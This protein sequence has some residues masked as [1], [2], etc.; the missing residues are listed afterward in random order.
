M[1][2]TRRPGQKPLPDEKAKAQETFL[3]VF[4]QTAIVGMAARKA[5]IARSTVYSWLD[6]DPDFKAAFELA[7]KDANDRLREAIYERGVEGVQEVTTVTGKDGEV[8]MR[9]TVR[10]YDTRLLVLL[11]QARMP[12]FRTSM[13]VTSGGKPLGAYEAIANAAADPTTTELA[14]QLLERF[15]HAEQRGDRWRADEACNQGNND[16]AER[17]RREQCGFDEGGERAFR[18]G[19]CDG[20]FLHRWMWERPWGMDGREGDFS[21]SGI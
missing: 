7:E 10:K 21:H 14:S 19:E 4:R 2:T 5:G 3:K 12:E 17:D 20:V 1:P 8:K 15:D 6:S 18:R 16:R 13:D 11:A 9:T